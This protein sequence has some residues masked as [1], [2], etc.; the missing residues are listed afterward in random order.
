LRTPQGGAVRLDGADV[1]QWEPSALGQHVGYL[2]QDVSLL[3]GTVAQNS[4][5]FG[6]IDDAAVVAAAQL[7][8]AHEMIVRLP[9]GYETLVGENGCRL[10][11]GQAQR[12]AFARALYG[13]PKLVVLDEPDAH[14]DADGQD[15]LKIALMALKARGATVLVA[16]HRAGLM[17]QMDRIAVLNDGAVQTFGSP[18]EV[19]AK[20]AAVVRALPKHAAPIAP[21]AGEPKQ[22][23][24]VAAAAGAPRQAAALASGAARQV[25]A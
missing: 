21:A 18:A 12:I 7:A 6:A 13:E 19:L 22:Q 8:G 2:P 9:E 17:A 10:S 25:A 16:G 5:R 24:P 20:G 14:L 11:G 4:A 23:T 3:S 15:A 1:A